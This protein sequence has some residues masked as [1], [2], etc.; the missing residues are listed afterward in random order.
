MQVNIPHM[1]CLGS[2]G[3]HIISRLKAG[4]LNDDVILTGSLNINNTESFYCSRGLHLGWWPFQEK[5]VLWD[6]FGEKELRVSLILLLSDLYA[7]NRCTWTLKVPWKIRSYIV[8][9][10]HT[11]SCFGSCPI[12]LR[13]RTV[14]WV[15]NDVQ[16]CKPSIPQAGLP[17][18]LLRRSPLDIRRLTG[19]DGADETRRRCVGCVAA[20]SMEQCSGI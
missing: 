7:A 18:K 15:Q 9:P 13:V 20:R 8:I 5:V 14:R 1:E 12:D 19:A 2:G 17:E 16:S 11:C 4:Y 3:F 10:C 6:A